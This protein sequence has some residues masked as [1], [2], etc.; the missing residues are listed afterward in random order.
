VVSNSAGYG[1]SGCL[2]REYLC[3]LSVLILCVKSFSYHREQPHIDLMVQ[4]RIH[5]EHVPW[6][7]NAFLLYFSLQQL[8]N[9]RASILQK[10][11][12]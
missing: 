12:V 1:N 11:T 2:D 9:N 8:Q 5:L 10:K 7:G 3:Y 4:K 6:Q